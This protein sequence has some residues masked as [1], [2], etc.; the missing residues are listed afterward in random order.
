MHWRKREGPRLTR[1][2]LLTTTQW[3]I[4]MRALFMPTH[5]FILTTTTT[6]TLFHLHLAGLRCP[7]CQ[8]MLVETRA[9]ESRTGAGRQRLAEPTTGCCLAGWGGGQKPRVVHRPLLREPQGPGTP[10]DPAQ[11]QRGR[12]S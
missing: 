5:W 4:R 1:I 9:A 11:Q 7:C 3:T 2:R 8:A 10:E 12:K 6:P